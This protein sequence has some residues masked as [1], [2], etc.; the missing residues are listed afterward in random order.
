MKQVIRLR[1]IPIKFYVD[2]ASYNKT[3]RKGGIHYNLKGGYKETQ[4]ERALGEQGRN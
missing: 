3:H 2:G 1:G 4:I